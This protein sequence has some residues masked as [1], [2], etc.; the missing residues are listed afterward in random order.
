MLLGGQTFRLSGHS[1]ISQ[2][3]CTLHTWSLRD[4]NRSLNWKNGK[5]FEEDSEEV[6]S[7]CLRSSCKFQMCAW[8][9]CV[10]DRRA[11]ALIRDAKQAVGEGKV[12]RLKPD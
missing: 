4:Y 12:V 10:G 1:L 7:H 5:F 3:S 6:F 9:P 11:M 2:A 8:G